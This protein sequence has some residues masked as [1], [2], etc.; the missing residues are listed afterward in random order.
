MEGPRFSW[1]V[2]NIFTIFTRISYA[3][4]NFDHFFNEKKNVNVWKA[5]ITFSVYIIIFLLDLV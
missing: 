1:K 3:Y 5:R 4:K 2:W